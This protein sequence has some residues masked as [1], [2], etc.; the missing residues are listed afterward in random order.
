[1]SKDILY[2]P[3]PEKILK[4]KMWQFLQSISERHKIS[5]D[6]YQDLYQWSITYPE[7]FWQEI[8]KLGDVKFSHPPHSILSS[9]NHM[10]GSTWFEGATLNFAEHLL[11]HRSAKPALI[12]GN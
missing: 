4:T 9:P 12:F 2:Q 6:N 11:R 3:T 5:L 7:Q 10:E 1:M 8:L